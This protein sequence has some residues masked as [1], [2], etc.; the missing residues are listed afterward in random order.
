MT[1]TAR[2]LI[3]KKMQHFTKLGIVSTVAAVITMM[4]CGGH[5]HARTTPGADAALIKG[6]HVAKLGGSETMIS[7][8]ALFDGGKLDVAVELHRRFPSTKP[9]CSQASYFLLGPG[10]GVMLQ[11]RLPELCMYFT[12]TE[13][14]RKTQEIK[15]E[16]FSV[17]LPA[18]VVESAKYV[19]VVH[20]RVGEV[21]QRSLDTRLGTPGL[22]A[23]PARKL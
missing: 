11:V 4:G 2:C 6:R 22:F 13:A 21:A 5:S 3:F 19:A 23:L 18:H 7:Q 9:S 17:Q 8:F 20:H 14:K 10:R 16:S 15:R 1:C 12:G